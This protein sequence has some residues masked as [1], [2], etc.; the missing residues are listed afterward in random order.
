MKLLLISPELKESIFSYTEKDVRSFWFPRLSLPVLA[1]LT[2]PDVDVRLLDESI[3]KINF[4]EAVDL[5]GISVMTFLAPR[6]YEIAS[7]FHHRGVKVVLGGIHPTA[8]PEEAKAH[9]DSVV[10]GEA[11][12]LWPRLIQDFQKGELKPFYRQNGLP[13]LENLPHPR[14]DLLK[15]EAYLTA[16]CLQ[17]SRGCPFGCEL[18][19]VTNFFG[20]TYRLRPIKD[21]VKELESMP[22][23]YTIFVDDNIAGSRKYSMELF[24]A[25]KPLGI[26]WG[27]QSS[28]KLADDP[29][30]MKKAVESGCTA[31]FLGIES[32]SQENLKKVRKG[33]NRVEKYK[34]SIKKFL[35]NGI[36][37][38]TGMI[39]GF[40]GDDESVFERTLEF[41]E[42]NKVT[43]ST[44]AILT[45]LPGTPFYRQMEK[46]GRIFDRNF[47]HYDGRHVTFYPK[48]MTPETLQEGYYWFGHRLFSISSIFKR[49]VRPSQP[50]LMYRLA[51]NWT[52]R[53]M[54]NRTPKGGIS[55]IARLLHRIPG[56]L[57]SSSE[58]LIPNAPPVNAL[59]ATLQ[60]KKVDDTSGALPN[61]LEN[62]REE[63]IERILSIH[64]TYDEKIRTIR[65]SLK[66]VLDE[67]VVKK[68]VKRIKKILATGVVEVVVDCK[69]VVLF[70]R[71]ALAELLKLK[72]I[73]ENIKFEA[74]HP[75][76][77][78]NG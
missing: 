38:T 22:P 62:A 27:G 11:E 63:V 42:E 14:R 64:T 6:A 45:P 47:E 71:T 56:T 5:V 68:F 31:L 13:S 32:L 41:L 58:G 16:N 20:N 3:E 28:I 57:S 48:L 15:R 65:I 55:P 77:K 39:F 50:Y 30:L 34:E 76:S 1:A 67:K 37:I 17:A 52:F 74:L 9:A 23:G 7:E 10:V 69:E 43:M 4:D 26:T 12:G 54:A 40:D 78:G 35:D 66:G 33:F 8:M 29:E 19:S 36:N 60:Q 49:V 24:E 2:P 73:E 46:E 25:I 59:E 51:I 53:R 18:C 61:F 72:E 44:P 75:M 21:V 70:S